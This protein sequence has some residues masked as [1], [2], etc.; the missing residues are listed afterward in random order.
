MRLIHIEISA[1]SQR[2][3]AARDSQ[4][5]RTHARTGGEGGTV[6]AEVLALGVLQGGEAGVGALGEETVEET[7]QETGGE[8]MA[9]EMAA[10]MAEEMAAAMVVD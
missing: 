1:R 9:A 2:E 3:I 4:R 6:G 7:V 8:E 5:E 10:K